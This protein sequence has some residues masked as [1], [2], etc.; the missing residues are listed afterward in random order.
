MGITN[1]AQWAEEEYMEINT[2]Y[3]RQIVAKSSLLSFPQGLPGFDELRE[4][5]L[6]HEEGTSTVFYLQSTEDP[7][8]RLPVVTPGSC[9][10]NYRIELDDSEEQLLRAGPDDDMIVVLTLS[11]NQDNPQSGI[12]ANLMAPIIIN[13]SSRIGMQK[14]LHQIQGGVVIDAR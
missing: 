4:F 11:D 3:G 14:S 6:F 13:A 10:I 1:A 9:N 2:R 5:K 12:T 8:V 7:D